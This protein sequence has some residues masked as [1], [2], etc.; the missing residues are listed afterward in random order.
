MTRQSDQ[1]PLNL[2]PK[3]ASLASKQAQFN[4]LSWYNNTNQTKCKRIE[5]RSQNLKQSVLGEAFPFE[6]NQISFPGK[7]VRW[8]TLTFLVILLQLISILYIYIFSF[9]FPFL[10]P[11][12]SSNSISRKDWGMEA[13]A[14]LVLG[15]WIGQSMPY[16]GTEERALQGKSWK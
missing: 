13:G 9:W 3:Y 4:W 1:N 5:I 7:I 8:K 16:R 11:C 2:Q 6:K 10:C 14:H 12:S 15:A